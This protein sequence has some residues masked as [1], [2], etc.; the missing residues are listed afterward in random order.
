MW[1]KKQAE[2]GARKNMPDKYRNGALFRIRTGCH[3][4]YSAHNFS[5]RILNRIIIAH[6]R[7]FV[8]NYPKIVS[9]ILGAPSG[10]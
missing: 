10:E 4:F 7:F 6:S 2:K 5:N 8:N 1:G 9:I 3:C